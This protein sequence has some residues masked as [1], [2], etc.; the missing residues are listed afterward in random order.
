[1]SRRCVARRTCGTATR[2]YHVDYSIHYYAPLHLLIANIY[3]GT[4]YEADMNKVAEDPQTQMWWAMT[5]GKQESP[6]EGATGSGKDI[7]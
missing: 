1:M 7:P 2:P 4:D 5:D 6:V 3:T